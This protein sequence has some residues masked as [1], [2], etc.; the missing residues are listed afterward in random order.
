VRI[1]RYVVVEDCGRMINPAVV[2]GQIRGGVVQGLGQALLEHAAYDE[3]GQFLTA[4]FMDYLMPTAADAPSIEI[5]HLDVPGLDEHEF[6]GVGEGGAIAAPAAVVNA[7]ADALG[8]AVT[9]LPLTP[10]A[11]LELLDSARSRPARDP[12]SMR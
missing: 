2:E 6:R 9:T 10:V 11:V 5:E 12:T 7:V 4:T 1:P 3:D 8:V